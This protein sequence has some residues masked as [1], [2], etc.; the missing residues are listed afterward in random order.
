MISV[1]RYSLPS[2]FTF[3][4]ALFFS[5]V[6]FSQTPEVRARL[7]SD[8]LVVGE[9]AELILEV[10]DLRLTNWPTPPK[11][12][13]L[14]LKQKRH[15]APAIRGRTALVFVYNVSCFK[16]G[17]F[18]IPPFNF[19][20]GNTTLSTEKFELE[21]FPTDLL[22]VGA[23]QIGDSTFPYMSALLL[24]KGTAFVGETQSAVAKLYLPGNFNLR[25]IR[26]ID[27]EKEKIAA[28]RFSAQKDQGT[29]LREGKQYTVISYPSAVTPL[30]DGDLKLGPGDTQINLQ[31]QEA[32]R[33]IVSWAKNKDFE[34]QFPAQKLK[35]RPL[36]TPKP[37]DFQGAVGNFRLTALP[38]AT[39]V[40]QNENITVEVK[41]KGTGNF[42]QFPGPI[43][44]DEKKE[45][46]QFEIT[47]KP[48]GS[49][50]RS[51]SGEVE[52]SQVIRPEQVVAGLPPYAFTFFDPLLEKYRTIKTPLQPLTVLPTPKS[53]A[54]NEESG[55]SNYL[56]PSKLPLLV[57]RGKSSFP[58]WI[59]QIIPLGIITF[60]I[61]S[62]G[63]QKLARR[64]AVSLPAREFEDALKAVSAS[65]TERVS[66]YREAANFI[67]F[68]KGRSDDEDFAKIQNTR[69]DICFSPNVPPEAVST[70]EKT[71]VLESLKKLSPLIIFFLALVPDSLLA[72]N[73]DPK[74]AKGEIL[75][76]MES[77]PSR[78]HFHN[79]A[80]AEKTLGN[81]SEAAL[82]AYRYAAQGGDATE[83]FK[84][85]PGIRPR[86]PK[87]SERVSILPLSFYQQVFAAGLW[88]TMLIFFFF[89]MK[90]SKARK[91]LIIS[92]SAFA[93]LLLILGALSWLIYPKDV[94]FRHLSKM[95]VLIKE[96][97]LQAQPYQGGQGGRSVEPGSL[98]LV[99]STSREWVH[100][101]F[102]GEIKGWL[103][104]EVVQP[105]KE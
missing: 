52:F 82:W 34:F 8:F 55:D 9:K 83:L 105:I 25:N 90:Y 3:L 42:D 63:R 69:D 85:L 32:Q 20:Y 49:E 57:F 64:K 89:R 104:K 78:E 47:Q 98:G 2:I 58:I 91:T 80:L 88:G 10:Y 97:A 53:I 16:P 12:S 74:I 54:T 62:W 41:V 102:P 84:G 61:I 13:P 39:E 4:A 23:I 76:L 100:V 93:P 44:L 72:L 36:P 87:G 67:V 31:W 71:W 37:A 103:P 38:S 77:Q 48:Q 99:T 46:K 33:G 26:V 96:T 43:L 22:N 59:W 15:Y 11:V 73:S 17:R 94:S 60:F 81:Q 51:S 70:D 29:Y 6:V 30:T 19:R 24:E 66:F 40:R 7:T 92:F 68:W 1:S 56:T 28:W 27:L 14:T 21:V 95:S 65:S 101:E 45:W 5:Q 86:E 75:K 18:T 35:V 50:R 79:L